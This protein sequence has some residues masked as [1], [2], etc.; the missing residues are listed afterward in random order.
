MLLRSQKRSE[1]S[2]LIKEGFSL[3]EIIDEKSR[4]VAIYI[5]EE[6]SDPA[7]PLLLAHEA[8]HLFNP[9]VT[10]W[11]MEGAA[12]LFAIEFCASRGVDTT[13][14][15]EGF[16]KNKNDPYANAYRLMQELKVAFPDAYAQLLHTTQRINKEESWQRIDI[17][18]WLEK[19]SESERTLA[20]A[21]IHPYTDQLQKHSD[22]TVVFTLPLK[23]IEMR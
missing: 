15:E 21:I 17:D 22:S 14:W 3:T 13:V 6:R 11:Y 16:K 5:G 4:S 7:Y 20:L 19:R 10:D 12:T 8:A 2:Y 18:H 23:L 9:Y 1:V